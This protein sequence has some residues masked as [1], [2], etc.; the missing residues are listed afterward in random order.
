MIYTY[1]TGSENVLISPEAKPLIDVRA[2]ND[3]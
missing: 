1:I 3:N 2:F